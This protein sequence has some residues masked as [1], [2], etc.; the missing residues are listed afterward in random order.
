MDCDNVVIVIVVIFDAVLIALVVILRDLLLVYQ[1]NY[2]FKMQL[3]IKL[4]IERNMVRGN[5]RYI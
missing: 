5:K 4:K 3:F 1:K 2:V